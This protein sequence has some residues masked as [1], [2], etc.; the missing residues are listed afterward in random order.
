[1]E[2]VDGVEVDGS[3]SMRRDVGRGERGGALRDPIANREGT[4]RLL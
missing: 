2:A 3:R 1:M 4:R